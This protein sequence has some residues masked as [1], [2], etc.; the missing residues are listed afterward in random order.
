MCYPVLMQENRRLLPGESSHLEGN[1][2]ELK[3]KYRALVEQ[4]PAVLYINDV[5]EDETTL[6]VSP[7]ADR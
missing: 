7:Q 4:I 5:D 1:V 6:Y 2:T 3:A